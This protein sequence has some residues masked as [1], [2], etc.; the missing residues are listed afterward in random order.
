MTLESTVMERNE[1]LKEMLRENVF[2]RAQI[3]KLQ[4][5]FGIDAVKEVF[6]RRAE[7]PQNKQQ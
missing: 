5:E 2:M 4:G 7:K 6:N 3:K 1:R